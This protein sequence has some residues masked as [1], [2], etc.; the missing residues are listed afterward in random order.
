[1]RLAPARIASSTISLTISSA[2]RRARLP[3]AISF[4][5]RSPMTWLASNASII[6][7]W[8]I[9]C[10]P[11]CRNSVVPLVPR[12][13]RTLSE[14]MPGWNHQSWRN[15]LAALLRSGRKKGRAYSVRLLFFTRRG[16]VR[17]SFWQC[18]RFGGYGAPDLRR[19]A[20][21]GPKLG[22]PDPPYEL[23]A[24][25]CLR[26][27]LNR[28]FVARFGQWTL[29]ECGHRKLL[30]LSFSFRLEGFRR[31]HSCGGRSQATSNL[32]PWAS[33]SVRPKL[34]VLVARRM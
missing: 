30:S 6:Q 27:Y 13:P 2:S 9:R 34:M 12:V 16:S 20:I 26:P 21:A 15:D 32:T 1:M 5:S 10:F 33:G 23:A 25:R 18:L 11:N 14:L 31:Q 4:N 7:E 28:R 22:A 29:S 24:H 17:R 19:H 8:S 3:P